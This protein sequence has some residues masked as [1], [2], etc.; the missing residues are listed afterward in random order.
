MSVAYPSTGCSHWKTDTNHKVIYGLFH[1][2]A[3]GLGQMV[4]KSK[5]ILAFRQNDSFAVAV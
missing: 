3:I 4:G 5:I 2:A 1:A